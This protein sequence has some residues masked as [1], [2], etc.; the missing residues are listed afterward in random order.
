MTFTNIQGGFE[1]EGNISADPLLLDP[2]NGDCHLVPGSPCIDAGTNDAPGIQETDFEDDP[3]ILDGDNDG[4]A[5]VD[6]GA[7]ELLINDQ[8]TWVSNGTKTR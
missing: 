4:V 1:G 2:E 7:D 3:R 5:I 6:M 8:I